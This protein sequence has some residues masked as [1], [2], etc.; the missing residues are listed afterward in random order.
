VL[1]ERRQRAGEARLLR[2]LEPEEV[3]ELRADDEQTRPR[4]EA[5]DHGDRDEVDERAEARDAERK[6]DQPDHQAERQHELD[7]LR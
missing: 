3:S 7:V 6:L 1:P 2:D 4:R 5:H